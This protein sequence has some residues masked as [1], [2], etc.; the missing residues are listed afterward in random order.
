[1]DKNTSWNMPK[2]RAIKRPSFSGYIAEKTTIKI[3][4]IFGMI[5]YILKN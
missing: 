1:M 4:D 2:N 5:P 3:K